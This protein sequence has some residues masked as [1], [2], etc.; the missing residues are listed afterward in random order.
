[1]SGSI[2]AGTVWLLGVAAAGTALVAWLPGSKLYG[3]WQARSEEAGKA[4]DGAIEDVGRVVT[5]AVVI[6]AGWAFAIITCWVLGLLAHRLEPVVDR[7]VFDWF[8]ARQV[9]GWTQIWHVLTQI[10]NRPETQAL[11]VVGAVVF[12]LLLGR[13]RWWIPLTL[14]PVGYL[15]EKFGGQILKQMVDR[16]HPPTTLGTWVSGGCARLVVVYGLLIFF[17]LRWRRVKSR[18]VKVSAWS[19][20][21]FLAAVEAY[22]RTYLLKHWVTD[23][24]GGLVFGTMILLVV[25]MAAL[26]LDR[27]PRGAQAIPEAMAEKDATH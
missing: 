2:V 25:I 14:L 16:G 5:A 20:L 4:A 6:L 7:P 15:L 18:R 9:G 1:M 21:A 24:V 26:V 27:V 23:V 8:A 13:G 3:A 12:A 10:G 19:A 11:T 22:S 17:G